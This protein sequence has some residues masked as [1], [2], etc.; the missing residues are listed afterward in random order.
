ME[1]FLCPARLT[2]LYTLERHTALRGDGLI[3]D[4]HAHSKYPLLARRCGLERR[5]FKTLCCLLT[6]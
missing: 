2:V 3:R 1:S 4:V 6:V 5:G